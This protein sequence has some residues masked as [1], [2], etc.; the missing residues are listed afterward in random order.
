MLFSNPRV[1]PALLFCV[2]IAVFYMR[3]K[4]LDAMPDWSAADIE[5]AVELNLALDL[6]REQQR[7][8]DGNPVTINAQDMEQRKQAIR[9]ELQTTVIAK[10]EEL[11]TEHRQA[12]IISIVGAVLM[13]IVLVLQR[14]GVLKK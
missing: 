1:L 10:R 9:E 2:G 4:E 7:D 5:T 13:V 12:L 11:E 6:A 14:T 8:A 3:G